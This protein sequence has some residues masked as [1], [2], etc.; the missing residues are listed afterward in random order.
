MIDN[1]VLK[2]KVAKELKQLKLT[3]EQEEVVVKE[4]N[5]LAD[6]LIDVYIAQTQKSSNKEIMQN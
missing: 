3:A 2:K 6:L 4:L 1:D 5:Y